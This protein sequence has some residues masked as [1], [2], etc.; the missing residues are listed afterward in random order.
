MLATV[1]YNNSFF[2]SGRP[3]DFTVYIKKPNIDYYNNLKGIKIYD[4]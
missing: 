1:A 2:S 4:D 3:R